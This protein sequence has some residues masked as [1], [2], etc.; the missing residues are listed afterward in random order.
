[1]KHVNLRQLLAFVFLSVWVAT[2]ALAQGLP[3]G[4]PE[5]LGFDPVRLARLDPILQSYIDD[6]RLAGSVALVLRD[7]RIVYSSAKG[8]SNIEAGLPMREDSIFRIASQTKAIVSTGIMMLHERGDL[9]ISDP[10]S[11]YFPEWAKV[12][13]AQPKADGGYDLVPIS[14]PITLRDLLTHTSGIGYGLG[15]VALDAWQQAGIA[16]WYFAN[17]NEPI[18]TTVARM[19]ALPMQAQPGEQW[20]YGYNLDIL[21]AVI[22]KVSGQSLADFLQQEIFT[23]LGMRDTHFYLPP[24]KAGRLAVVYTPKTGGGIERIRETGGMQSQGMYVEGPRRSY[25]GGAGLLSTAGD[26]A[27]FLQMTLNG[28]EF[29]GKRL[30]S[31]KTIELMTSNHLRDI[32]FQPG[33]GFGLGFSIAMDLGARGTLGSVGEYGWGGAY[34]STYWVD[35][36]EKLVVVYLSQLIPAPGIDDFSKLRAGIY[37]ALVKP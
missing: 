20:I 7:G 23:P 33:T 37:Q 29:N 11:R 19:A 22:E 26:Y 5:R 18:G 10:L 36:V 6:Q 30:L 24:E 16:G 13:V 15:G 1:M 3:Q 31:P 12:Q 21:G 25:S 35:P 8:M 32:P 9:Q 28:G 14:R 4:R 27:R 2:Q 34:H 17:K